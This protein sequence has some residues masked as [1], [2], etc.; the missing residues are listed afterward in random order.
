MWGHIDDAQLILRVAAQ[1]G[2]TT[3]M[4]GEIAGGYSEVE[5]RGFFSERGLDGAVLDNAGGA[6]AGYVYYATAAPPPAELV[7][8]APDP[9]AEFLG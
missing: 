9:G 1:Y 2:V 3:P 5:V 7:G 4:L 6:G 8:M